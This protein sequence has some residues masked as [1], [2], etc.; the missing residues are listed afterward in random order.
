MQ[1]TRTADAAAE[2]TN[3]GCYEESACKRTGSESKSNQFEEVCLGYNEKEAME[4]AS[5]CLNCKNAMCMKGCPVSINIPAFIH[6]VK[7][8]N[9]LRLIRLSASH[10]L[11]RLCAD[12]YVHR[13]HSVKAN[14]SEESRVSLYHR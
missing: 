10:Q 8:G 9:L 11:F 2:V 1:L 7:E 12:V 3:N 13:N 14:V 5:R 6:E 4:E